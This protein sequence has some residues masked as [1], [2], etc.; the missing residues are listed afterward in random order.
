MAVDSITQ[1]QLLQYQLQSLRLSLPSNTATSRTFG[2]DT[3]SFSSKALALLRQEEASSFTLN[4]TLAGKISDLIK[5]KSPTTF[6][7]LDTDKNNRLSI[8]EISKSLETAKKFLDVGGPKKT[9]GVMEKIGE[10]LKEKDPELF[11]KIDTDK[12]GI[13]ATS[14]LT[15]NQKKI[16]EY[17]KAQRLAE[18][19]GEEGQSGS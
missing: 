14:E 4:E 11:K 8:G 18:S 17:Y 7:N 1:A 19:S 2:I 15:S 9:T 13:L 16:T 6:Q 12:N 10:R 5:K 3:A